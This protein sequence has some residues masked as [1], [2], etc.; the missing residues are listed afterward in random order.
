MRYNKHMEIK[1]QTFQELTNEELYAILK[2]R[3]EVFVVE[4]QCAYLDPDGID[5]EAM[6]ISLWDT[7]LKAY[8]RVFYIDKTASILQ[9]GRVVS[10]ERG[11]GYGQRVVEEALQYVKTTNAKEMIVEAQVYAK[12]FYERFGFAVCSKEFLEDGIPHIKMSLSL[13]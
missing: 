10:K 2:L 13:C 7:E 6:H 8:A 4:Q 9:M 12:A 5:I 3:S 11:Q 1:V